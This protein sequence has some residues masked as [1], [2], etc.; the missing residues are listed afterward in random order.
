[1]VKCIS[2]NPKKQDSLTF[3]KAFL[4]YV[5][6]RSSRF[7]KTEQGGHDG[8]VRF[9]AVL[10]S[11]R[12]KKKIGFCLGVVDERTTMQQQHYHKRHFITRKDT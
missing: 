6:V 10:M 3:Y 8:T 11:A 4:L 5:A 12:K 1:M 7:M 2:N 9:G